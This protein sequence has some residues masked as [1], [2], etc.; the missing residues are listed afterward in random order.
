MALRFPILC[1]TLL[2]LGLTSTLAQANPYD[3]S[4][5]GLGGPTK[6]TSGQ[7]VPDAA[8]VKRFRS[9]ASELTIAIMPKPMEPA[10]TLGVSGFDFAAGNTFTAIHSGSDYWQGQPGMP[11]ME[12]TLPNHGNHNVPNEL[13]TPSVQFRKGLPFSTEVGVS[14]GYLAFTNMYM[15]SAEAKV[16]IYESFFHYFPAIGLRA[17]VGR[18]FGSNELDVT[19]A[20]ADILASLAFGIGG[21]IQATV[22]GGYGQLYTQINSSVLNA[23]PYSA[24]PTYYAFPTIGWSD[25]MMPRAV[26]GIRLNIS[27]IELMYEAD[28]TF[29]PFLKT[30][31][32]SHTVKIGFDV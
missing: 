3:I 28:W 16:A 24:T 1:G 7:L 31:L 32:L 13:W 8:T 4:L 25:N 29:M 11:V 17:A 9:L 26:G 6:N 19:T 2:S 10:E 12:G 5:R 20:E 21:M 22:Y 30:Q 23:T 18:L 15:L 14:A 27:P